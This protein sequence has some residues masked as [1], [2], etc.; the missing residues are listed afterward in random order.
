MIKDTNEFLE[1]LKSSFE[2]DMS[3]AT[4]DT[5]RP[6]TIDDYINSIST[7]EGLEL[8]WNLSKK[9]VDYANYDDRARSFFGNLVKVADHLLNLIGL[10]A[11]LLELLKMNYDT[12]LLDGSKSSSLVLN[13]LDATLDYAECGE[14]FLITKLITLFLD[15][16]SC[17]TK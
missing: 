13:Q 6:M 9:F 10:D 11:G 8:F 2:F 14:K 12:Y 17:L 1:L 3:W 5:D 7:I 4:V 16:K 15:V